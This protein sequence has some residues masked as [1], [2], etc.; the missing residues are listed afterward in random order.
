MKMIK[1]SKVLL[2]SSILAALTGCGTSDD[3]TPEAKANNAAP[4]HGGDISVALHEK[5]ALRFVDLLGA[6]SGAS[7]GEG[8]ATDADGSFMSVT[9]VSIQASGPR[10]SDIAALGAELNGNQIAI[11][12]AAI[13]P[14]LDNDETHTI[15]VNYNIS[16][17]QNKTPR[18]A[19]F[20]FAGEDFA[21]VAIG[22][23]L[24]NYTRDAGTAAV[25]MLL[26]VTD[27]DGEALTI[28]NVVASGD[29][30]FTLPVT[31]N[32]TNLDVDIAAVES[33]IPDG[34]KVSFDFTYTISD[35]RFSIDRNLTINVLGVQD[36]PGAPLVTN[37]FKAA[38]VNE[39]DSV[40]TVDLSDE[41]VEREGDAIVVSDVM[42]D[43]DPLPYGYH[44]DGNMLSIDPHAFFAD[45]A[46]GK[47]IEHR[48]T[49]KVS[50]DQ[51]NM[52]DGIPE[53]TV[54][55][56][57]EQTNL[58]A[59]SGFSAGFEDTAN[60]GPLDQNNNP[61]GFVWGW[62]GWGCPA[63]E[64]RSASARTGDYGMLMQG[65]FCHFEIHNIIPM[66]EDDQKY[67]MSYWLRNEASNGAAGNP[68]VPLFANVGDTGLNNRFWWGS[69]Y[70]DQSLNKW[71]EHVQLINTNEAGNWD[72]Y[73]ALAVHFGLL[74]YDDSYSGGKH[75]IDDLS[76]VKFGHFDTAAHDMIVD[77]FGM[78]ENAEA[79][80]VDAGIAEIRDV[81]GMNKLYVDTTGAADGVTISLPIKAGAIRAGGR[82]AVSL[83]A[84][85]INHDALYAPDANTQVMYYVGLSN[86]TES[87]AGNGNGVTWG[88][89]DSA[90]DVIIT[91]EFGRTADVDWSG[92]TMTLNILLSEANAQY[93]IDN[94]R[95]IAIP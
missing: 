49:Y 75:D 20:T 32:G 51:G 24:A 33:Q 19:T 8:V 62:A 69:R 48:V 68:Y 82:Y 71:M 57:G 35:H 3:F 47:F 77:D 88:P 65:S 59:A 70:F 72:G 31:I 38:T 22:D 63:K 84:Q 41:I 53:F 83:N 61:G 13:A 39:T 74:K 28:S 26:N 27:A 76:M 25:N 67:A 95:L 50:D 45:V 55:I 18:S 44:L 58:I 15:V 16:D 29:N 87:V 85:L 78:F 46:A 43:G 79:M 86:G 60:L 7:S 42:L 66:L 2:A 64:I 17:G 36:V 14:L 5:D 91:E 56:N 73:E 6:P 90:A 81:E 92:E 89:N 93:Y 37:Y 80:T 40:L 30:P 4:V 54:V 34:Q 11:R 23:N 52:S 9:D 94:V 10:A 1:N 21:P 12:P